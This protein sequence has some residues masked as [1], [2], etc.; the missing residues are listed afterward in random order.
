VI[1]APKPVRASGPEL[2]PTLLQRV[3]ASRLQTFHQCR[4]KFYFRY[5]LKLKKP[6]T[7]ALHVGTSVHHVL[8]CWNRAR[9]KRDLID[10]EKLRV[11]FARAWVED[12]TKEPVTWDRETPEASEMETAWSLV[13]TYL[14]QTPIPLEERPEAVEVAVEADLS[15]HGLPLLVGFI[16][17]VRS[18]GRIVDYKTA[19]Q[20][21][22]ADRAEHLHEL[23]LSCYGLLYRDATGQKEGGFELH[24]LVKLKTP[25]LVLSQMQPMSEQQESR[26][27]RLIESYVTGVQRQDWVPNPN[28]MSCACCEY[29]NECRNWCGKAVNGKLNQ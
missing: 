12:Q 14:A 25:K 26:L 10:L 13:R 16:D 1:A 29:F 8:Q 17:L 21:P 5:V 23:Q 20:T 15:S 6:K 3:S 19:G 9:W 22:N 24:H 11:E 18:G 28:V 4:L 27:F 7:A 2:I